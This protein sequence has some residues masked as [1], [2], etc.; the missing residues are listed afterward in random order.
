MSDFED[1][2]FLNPNKYYKNNPVLRNA[3]Y[4]YQY[5]ADELK[6][7]VKCSR[8]I[9][10]FAEKYVYITTVDD[11]LKLVEL[12]DYQKVFLRQ[13]VANQKT[14]AMWCR[15]SGKG[16]V[17]AIFF[18]WYT[19][20]NQ[21]KKCAILA[22]KSAVARET[23]DKFKVGYE[24]LPFFLKQGIT[25]YNKT[26]V[27]FENGSRFMASSTTSNAIRGFT[28]NCLVLDELAFVHPNIAEEFFTSVFPTISSGKSTKIII[29]STP[30]G[31]G[32]L[33]WRLYTEA[34]RGLNGFKYSKVT[35][36]DVGIWDKQWAKDQQDTLGEI[37]FNQEFQVE[38]LGSKHTLISAFAIKNMVPDIPIQ[39]DDN[40][41]VYKNP[42]RGRH[43]FV[44]CDPS[45]GTGRD[46]S[47]FV[48]L[49][50]TEYPFTICATY[51]NDS[52]SPILLPTVLEKIAKQYNNAYVLIEINDNGQQVADILY[53]DLE[54]E[55]VVSMSFHGN[56]LG[57][58]TTTSV[59][60]IGCSNFKDIV[61]NTKLII[62]DIDLISQISTF[63][64]D[65][66][67]FSA[68]PGNYDDLVMA[69][70]IFSWFLT[71]S[72]FQQ[73]FDL[74]LRH[75]IRQKHMKAIEE[76]LTPFGFFDDGRDEEEE[77]VT[78]EDY[79]GLKYI[80]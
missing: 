78:V 62:N 52:I 39:Q 76:N 42:E 20:F 11:G 21:D 60:R 2:D 4:N 35:W 33:F 57:V 54:Y 46:Y 3:G 61:E 13:C 34:E 26:S 67:S 59:K 30:N 8:D 22:N 72:N 51:L 55:N 28:I 66:K 70:V 29:T 73:L 65:K 48:V 49:D 74:S 27:E 12:R 47:A 24:N 17:A 6:E 14:I 68:E 45:R 43:Y 56:E 69:C 44:S 53:M 37:K 9:V 41:K 25:T 10:Y 58:R 5:S 64:Q 38:F 23:M 80:E 75:E 79:S 31:M 19:L 50:I 63:A 32:N 71:T 1:Q 18:L 40:L 16:A 77:F 7:Y 36:E 15:R